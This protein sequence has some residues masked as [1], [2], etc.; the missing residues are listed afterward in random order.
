MCAEWGARN[1]LLLNGEHLQTSLPQAG[2][3]DIQV[4][5][6]KWD[7]GDWRGGMFPESLIFALCI[8]L[9]PSIRPGVEWFANTGVWFPHSAYVQASIVVALT[10]LNPFSLPLKF[11]HISHLLSYPSLFI[12]P[13][14]QFF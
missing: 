12:H 2:F 1:G 5:P 11:R 13:I 4:I 7:I 14:F 8:F 3:T 10:V 9:C 6:V